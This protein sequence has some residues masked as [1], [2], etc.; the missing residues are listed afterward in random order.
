M[1][2]LYKLD[3]DLNYSALIGVFIA[4]KSYVD[5]LLENKLKLYFGEVAGKHSEIR[6]SLEKEHIQFI[7]DNPEVIKVVEEYGLESGYNPFN[8]TVMGVGEQYIDMTAYEYIEEQLN[9]EI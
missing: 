5:Y 8:Y 2:A 3:I 1:K 7:T 9:I 4:P 6:G